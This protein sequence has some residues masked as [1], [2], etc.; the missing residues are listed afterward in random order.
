MSLIINKLLQRYQFLRIFYC[1]SFHQFIRQ[2][3][4][5]TEWMERMGFMEDT[6]EEYLS[7]LAR[8]I[9]LGG[10]NWSRGRGSEVF[11]CSLQCW[12]LDQ[13]RA[14]FCINTL[15]Y[16]ARYYMK[17]TIWGE[18]GWLL[19]RTRTYNACNRNVKCN[20][21]ILDRLLKAPSIHF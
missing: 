2:Y 7:S 20:S 19:E 13:W 15:Q 10:S 4:T 11:H 16:Q 8:L 6:K 9:T 17:N 14:P 5:R 12:R 21:F 3:N 18:I 1:S